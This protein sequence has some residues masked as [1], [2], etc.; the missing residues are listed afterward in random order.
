MNK[1]N[2]TIEEIMEEFDKEFPNV[3]YVPLQGDY[4]LVNRKDLKSFL[5]Q[6]ITQAQ[7]EEKKKT[8]EKLLERIKIPKI[9]IKY[10]NNF[11]KA[12]TIYTD[13]RT[14]NEDWSD[15]YNQAVADLEKLKEE[16]KKE[17]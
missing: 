6:A 4:V 15:G 11:D 17:L 7:Q 9:F 1:Q 16:I 3:K 12:G 2:K 10:V 5:R 14:K 8:K 13:D